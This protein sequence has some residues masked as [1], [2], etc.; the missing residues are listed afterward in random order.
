MLYGMRGGG[1]FVL[2]Q[3]PSFNLES[4]RLVFG[5]EAR[6]GTVEVTH[7][8]EQRVFTVKISDVW[9]GANGDRF[10]GSCGLRAARYGNVLRLIIER[11]TFFADF[12]AASVPEKTTNALTRK[13]FATQCIV[14]LVNFLDSIGFFEPSRMTALLCHPERSRRQPRRRV[15]QFVILRRRIH[16]L[17]EN[18]MDPPYGRMTAWFDRAK[19][20]SHCLI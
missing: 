15:S 1:L 5:S 3:K 2:R 10:A 16:T 11:G 13:S 12:L 8:L 4:A 20:L 19:R 17:I 6:A 18:S 9:I 14:L 7:H